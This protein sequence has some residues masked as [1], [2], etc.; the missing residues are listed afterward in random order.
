MLS[1]HLKEI[2]L[3]KKVVPIHMPRR[4]LVNFPA[5]QINSHFVLTYISIKELLEHV[6]FAS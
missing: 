6:D 2:S 1:R 3:L 5:T 4:L